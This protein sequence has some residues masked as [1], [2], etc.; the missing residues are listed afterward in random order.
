MAAFT[1]SGWFVKGLKYLMTSVNLE[2]D[3]LIAI[4][5]SAIPDQTA[6]EFVGDLSEIN[7]PDSRATIAGRSF[8][9]DNTEKEVR[10]DAN[11]P[12]FPGIPDAV[13]FVGYV[14]AKYTGSDAT[15][16]LL[17][18][19]DTANKTGN[20]GDIIVEFAAAG[21]CKLTAS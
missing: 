18:W 14:I 1:A 5:V 13:S 3:T 11:D 8:T 15:S 12:T 6:D 10:L 4:P 7:A 21:T 9:V 17:Y 19:D 2:T 16:P 20:G